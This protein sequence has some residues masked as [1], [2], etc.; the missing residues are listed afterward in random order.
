MPS[1]TCKQ[2]IP[3]FF[4]LLLSF[5]LTSTQQ[6]AAAECKNDK[7]VRVLEANEENGSDSFCQEFLASISYIGT[8]RQDPTL[9]F[10]ET[11]TD[12]AST[13]I[14]YKYKETTTKEKVVSTR[15]DS[16]KRTGTTGLMPLPTYVQ[17]YPTPR[18][19]KAWYVFNSFTSIPLATC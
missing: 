17:Q 14:V 10:Y 3:L 8:L 15:F 5:R 7:I 4:C 18:V 9:F 16:Q 13:D 1:W 19:K 11:S 12:S 2:F 6:A